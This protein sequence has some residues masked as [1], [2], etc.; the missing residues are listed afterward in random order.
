MKQRGIASF[1]GA[2][3]AENA[4]SKPRLAS[5]TPGKSAKTASQHGSAAVLKDVNSSGIKRAREDGGQ[6]TAGALPEQSGK[7]KL[8]RIQKG[9]AAA[10]TASVQQAADLIDDETPEVLTT[11]DAEPATSSDNGAA[12]SADQPAASPRQGRTKADKATASKAPAKTKK[13]ASPRNKPAK[14]ASPPQHG[15][16]EV[17]V[18]HSD[19]EEQQ[20]QA[21]SSLHAGSESEGVQEVESKPAKAKAKPT[22][23][24]VLPD[25]VRAVQK[26]E[27]VG[28]GALAAAGKHGKFELEKLATW[29]AGQPVPFAFLADTFEAIAEESK[30][31]VITSLLV[32]CFRTIIATTPEDLLAT[33]YLCTNQVAP[34]HEGIELGIGDATLIK[35]LAAATGRQESLIKKQYGESGDLGIVASAARANQRTMYQPAPLTIPSVLKTFKE[36]ASTE[37]SKSMEK[38]KGLIQKL[39][40]A[41]RNNETGYIMRALQGKLR[42]GLAEQTVL[43]ALA[44][45]VLLHKQ[46]DKDKGKLAG[47]LEESAQIVKYVYS[48]CPSYD[49]LVPALLNHPISELKQRVAFVVG[50]PVKPMLAKPTMGVSEVLDKFQDIEFT[51]EYKYDGERAQVHISEG[52]KVSIYSRNSENNTSKYPDLAADVPKLLKEGCSSVVLDCEAVAYDRVTKKILPF[53]VLSTRARKDVKVADIKVQVCLYAFDCLF[54]NGKVLVDRPLTERREALYSAISEKPG[55]LFYATAKTS[56]ELE[57][58]STFLNEAVNVG[59]EGL[60]VKTLDS[61]Y[62]PSKR[63]AHWLKLKKDYLEGVGD[64]F[65]LVPIGAWYGKGKRTGVFG[66]FLLAIY[67]ENTEEYQTISKIG[68]GFSEEQL[69][70]LAD[71]LRPLTIKEP[72]SYYRYGETLV[73]DVWFE[74]KVVW[75]VKAADLSISPVHQAAA[76]MADAV[77]GISIRF[78][79][80]VRVR[81]DKNPEQAT[82]AEQVVEWYQ[83]QPHVQGNKTAKAADD[84]EY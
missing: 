23:K 20:P 12:L 72:R 42:I 29:K 65:D 25:S 21:S 33:V 6:S 57:E 63:S 76:G 40:V 30:R 34:S 16:S 22:K 52:G 74:P 39:V 8:R 14:E 9:S 67:N 2:G 45:A 5:V 1:F 83:K 73:P 53:Q 80:L 58:L 44:Q 79:R 26:V 32:N 77:K 3:K 49:Q 68:T 11:A 78:P 56:R 37:G 75:E 28:L 31:L 38:K 19:A 13:A 15:G 81:D 54:L 59:T 41:S 10:N 64:T 70:E 17:E 43:V 69:K 4:P 61:T 36:I 66:A 48:Q 62:E 50:V 47:Q 35:A 82:G 55:E 46:G 27:G 18:S 7:G 51:C 24:P 71:L 84:D 60:I